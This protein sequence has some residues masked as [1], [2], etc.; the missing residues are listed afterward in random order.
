MTQRL[1]PLVKWPG[2]KTRELPAILPLIG[3][4]ERYYEPFAGSGAVLFATEPA[5][6]GR[7]CDRNP[8][9][10]ELYEAMRRC[11]LFP[12]FAGRLARLR[13]ALQGIDALSD[14]RLDF[15][16]TRRTLEPYGELGA[17]VMAEVAKAARRKEIWMMKKGISPCQSILQTALQAGLF[18]AVRHEFNGLAHENLEPGSWH[19]EWRAALF[20]YVREYAFSGMFLVN[21]SGNESVAYGGASYNAK[22]FHRRLEQLSAPLMRDRLANTHFTLGDW[23]T[24]L[25]GDD[26]P[27]SRDTVFLDPPYDREFTSYGGQGFGHDEHR[28]LAD[29]IRTTPARVVLVVSSSDAMADIYGRI[30]GITLRTWEKT[31]SQTIKGRFDRKAMHWAYIKPAA[32][33]CVAPGALQHAA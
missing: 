23:S 2:S 22:S 26:A 4:P 6:K 15:P 27:D 12:G 9:L 10:V 21:R 28:R 11:S 30:P 18:T 19:S 5:I 8:H 13:E 33:A 31:Y 16:E 3:K 14:W 24:L 20:W 1:R 17:M 25:D 32:S 7:L 29:W